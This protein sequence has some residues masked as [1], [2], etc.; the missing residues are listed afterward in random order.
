MPT[1]DLAPDLLLTTTYS[2]RRPAD[3]GRPLDRGDLAEA[4]EIALSAAHVGS[5]ERG[6]DHPPPV[7]SGRPSRA[8]FV[9]VT[10]PDQ[11]QALAE[12]YRRAVGQTAASTERFV[13]VHTA[14]GRSS[15]AAAAD[16]MADAA[17]LAEHL[18]E[19]PA[20]VIPCIAWRADGL[21][22]A[23]QAALWGSI[24]P[25]VWSFLLAARTRGMSGIITTAHLLYEREAAG[26]LGIPYQEVMQA[27]LIPLSRTPDWTL[28]TRPR[29]P[30][31]A[32]LHWDRW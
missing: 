20:L 15:A 22:P 4:V 6:R 1:R 24:F 11:R 14:E 18:H 31:E 21:P 19:V 3:L 32:A 13:A 30:V 17:Y 10:D 26:V 29:P 28:P 9:V 5:L 8:H 12:L 25:A 2:I 23:S 16:G 27:A 7:A